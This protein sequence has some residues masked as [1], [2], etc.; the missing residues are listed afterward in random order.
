WLGQFEA[1]GIQIT[2]MQG[3]VSQ[4]SEVAAVLDGIQQQM[5]P[6]RG[7]IHCAGIYDDGLLAG[8]EWG[9]FERVFA[10]KV[11]GS[12]NLHALTANL[13]LDFLVLFSSASTLIGSPG[14]GHYV[15]A[16]TFMDTLAHY[17]RAQRLPA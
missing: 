2:V 16:N 9:R 10:P 6:L 13:P 1:D 4:E 17:R 12:W 11:Q 15:A 7:I 3:D 8:Q 14:Q 5:P